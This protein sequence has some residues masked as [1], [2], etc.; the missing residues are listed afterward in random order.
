[1]IT[2]AI[3]FALVCALAVAPALA[4]QPVQM[5]ANGNRAGGWYEA[6]LLSYNEVP[7]V[8]SPGWGRFSLKLHND[9]IE[10][11]LRYREL[12]GNAVAAHIHLGQPGTN[13]G[14]VAWLCGNMNTP[15]CP[16]RGGFLRGEIRPEDI[17]GPVG[18]GIE[19]GNFARAVGAIRVGA[20]YVNVHSELWPGGEIRGQL[21]RGLAAAGPLLP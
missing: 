1:M 8:Y 6:Y 15:A 5:E 16:A 3:R 4:D 7:A 9:R 18:Q 11:E 10:Y 20:T 12:D 19:P 14:V 21:R 2:K 13:G 17:V